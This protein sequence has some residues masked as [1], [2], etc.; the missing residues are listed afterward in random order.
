MV[1]YCKAEIKKGY[2]T[3]YSHR[4]RIGSPLNELLLRSL[5][6]PRCSSIKNLNAKE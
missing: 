4:N 1:E 5:K 2:I 6:L 3:R